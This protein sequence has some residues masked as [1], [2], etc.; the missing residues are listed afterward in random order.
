MSGLPKATTNTPSSPTARTS[1][2]ALPATTPRSWY[3]ASSPPATTGH[4]PPTRSPQAPTA[5]GISPDRVRSLSDRRAHAVQSRRTAYRHWHEEPLELVAERQRWI[6]QHI[7]RDRSQDQ[8]L[9]DG[10]DL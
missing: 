3:A 1:C 6:D 5:R 8:G 7:G 10:I 9:D 4:A 2:A